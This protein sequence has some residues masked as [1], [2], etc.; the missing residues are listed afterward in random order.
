[1]PSYTSESFIALHGSDNL[2]ADASDLG[3]STIPSTITVIEGDRTT[4][5]QF[6]RT[7]RDSEGDIIG[8]VYD[9]GNERKLTIYN[10]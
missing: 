2:I 5:A 9:M 10:D 3:M 7:R 8:W 6:A 4:V 1:M